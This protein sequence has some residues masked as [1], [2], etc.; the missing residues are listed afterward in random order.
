MSTIA[1]RLPA[2]RDGHALR[3]VAERGLWLASGDAGL[4]VERDGAARRGTHEI[5]RDDT[6]ELVGVLAVGDGFVA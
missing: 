1:S 4:S 5:T 2:I 6:I 3:P